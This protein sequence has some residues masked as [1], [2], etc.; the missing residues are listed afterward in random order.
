MGS[1]LRKCQRAEPGEQAARKTFGSSVSLTR[2]DFGPRKHSKGNSGHTGLGKSH[3]GVILTSLG[4]IEDEHVQH[5]P[6]TLLTE[7]R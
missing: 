1:R 5:P 7:F 6:R 2:L 3:L 4:R